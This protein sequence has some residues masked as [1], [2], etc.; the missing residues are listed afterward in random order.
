MRGRWGRGRKGGRDG[1]RRPFLLVKT[2]T[3]LM[4][5]KKAVNTDSSPNSFCTIEKMH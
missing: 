2:Q 4:K 3:L 1:G 5:K